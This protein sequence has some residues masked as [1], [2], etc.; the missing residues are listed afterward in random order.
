MVAERASPPRR[1]ASTASRMAADGWESLAAAA[2]GDAAAPLRLRRRS[3]RLH[4][5]RV[6]AAVAAA[7]EPLVRGVPATSARLSHAERPADLRR[8]HAP[9]RAHDQDRTNDRK[10]AG[11]LPRGVRARACAAAGPG[12]APQLGVDAAAHRATA[13]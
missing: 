6:Q 11:Y 9:A 12:A 7:G 1:G 13:R 4:P 10:S 3:C 8:G 5:H 2:A